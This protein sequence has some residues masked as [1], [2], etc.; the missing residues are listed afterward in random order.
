VPN[1]SFDF[2]R[3][4]GFQGAKRIRAHN[5]EWH[6]LLSTLPNEKKKKINL[7]EHG[8]RISSFFLGDPAFQ[9]LKTK[10]FKEDLGRA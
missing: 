10:K 7:A 4:I 9:K 8:F 3:F 6:A 5:F 1:Y 2:F